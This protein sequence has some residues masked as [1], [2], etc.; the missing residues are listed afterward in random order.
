MK[1]ID[2]YSFCKLGLYKLKLT[3]GANDGKLDSRCQD[4]IWCDSIFVYKAYQ[5]VNNKGQ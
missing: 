4:E 1:S 2:W 5:C 3:T